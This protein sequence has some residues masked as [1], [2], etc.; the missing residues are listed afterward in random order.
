[1]E[2]YFKIGCN[3]CYNVFGGDVT[4]H[5]DYLKD[6]IYSKIVL[7]MNDSRMSELLNVS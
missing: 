7:G 5:F 2:C 3:T 6:L 4:M 1:M